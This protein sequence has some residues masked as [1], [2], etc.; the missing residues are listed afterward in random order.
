MNNP[1]YQ[2]ELLTLVNSF[3]QAKEDHKRKVHEL[4][5][6]Y[7]KT[8]N[9]YNVGDYLYCVSGII[10]VST[11]EYV[12]HFNGNVRKSI[13]DFMRDGCGMRPPNIKLFIELSK[14]LS[15]IPLS[16]RTI[17]AIPK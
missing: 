8:I 9:R 7:V 10:K 15:E 12:V 6:K 5:T 16:I 14:L 13:K 17:I 4:R 11:I 2:N 3:E 1:E